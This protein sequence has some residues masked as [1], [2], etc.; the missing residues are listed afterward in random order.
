MEKKK[1][2]ELKL[3]NPTIP[4]Q[5]IGYMIENTGY[6]MD[7]QEGTRIYFNSWMKNQD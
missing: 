1:K 7:S 4:T 5:L 3:K 6:D 2:K